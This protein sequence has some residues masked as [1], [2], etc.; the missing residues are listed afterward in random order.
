[1]SNYIVKSTLPKKRGGGEIL[2]ETEYQDARLES[3]T[4]YQTNLTSFHCSY[5]YYHLHS[6]EKQDFRLAL[7]SENSATPTIVIWLCFRESTPINKH[8]KY[9]ESVLS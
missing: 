4:V 2:S 7:M 8:D 5:I 9:I 1:M 6:V 3:L